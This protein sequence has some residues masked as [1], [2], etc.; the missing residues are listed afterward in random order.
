MI[1]HLQQLTIAILQARHVLF[2]YLFIYL[3]YL[4]NIYFT[5]LTLRYMTFDCPNVI[6]SIK[7]HKVININYFHSSNDNQYLVYW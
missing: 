6:I 1:L 2:Y 4:F 3:T 7:R 5:V